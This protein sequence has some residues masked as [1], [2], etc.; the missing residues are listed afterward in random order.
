MRELIDLGTRFTRVEEGGEDE[1]EVAAETVEAEPAPA[2]KPVLP[3]PAKSAQAE[4]APQA[5]SP[6]AREDAA[7][8]E[9]VRLDRFRK[10]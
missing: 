9:V 3:M 1:P 2:E 4:P 5:S 6:P 7:G 10:K 8:A